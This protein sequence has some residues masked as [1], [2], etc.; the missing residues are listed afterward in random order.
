MALDITKTYSLLMAV[1]QMFP[2]VT[3]LRDTYFPTN[4]ATDIFSTEYVL[5]EYKDGER[6]LAPFVAPR[7]GG[8]TILRDGSTMKSYEPPYI[9]PKRTMT[10]DELKKRGFGEAIL[11]E[12]TP[13]QREAQ[14]ALAD[15]QEMSEM[16][17]RREE[18]MAAETMLNNG[19]IMNHIADDEKVKFEKEIRFYDEEENPAKYTPAKTWEEAD[20]NI[21]GDLY[22]MAMNLKQRGLPAADFICAPDVAQIILNDDTIYKLLDNRRIEVGTIAPR[23]L[24]K[25]VTLTA[26]L[27][28]YGIM[29]D[30]LTYPETYQADDGTTKQFIPAGYGI[31]TAPAAGRT[32]YGAVTQMEQT[33]HNYHTYAG[34][35][36]PK[37]YADAKDDVREIYLKSRPLLIPNNKNPWLSGKFTK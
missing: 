29:I 12:L 19:C 3:F 36:V 25:G 4:D 15:M 23:E 24:P 21:L 7:K 33:D 8:V 28:V 11:T 35:R 17:A 10:I 5:V 18:A 31:M 2:P 32:L 14:L 27:N 16:I 34:R 30:V 22:A 6:K 1:K 13:A 9:A 20:S 26:R 37:Y